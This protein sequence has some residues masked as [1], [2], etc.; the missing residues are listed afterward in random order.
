MQ[1][2]DNYTI[3]IY[4]PHW[5][6]KGYQA[7]LNNYYV[8]YWTSYSTVVELD[9][10]ICWQFMVWF[11]LLCLMPLST[12][13]QLYQGSQFYWRK[14]EYPVKTTNLCHK[15]LTK[16]YHIMLHRIL[17]MNGVRTHNFSG[18]STD[19]TG[20]FLK[21]CMLVYYH[22]QIRISWWLFD[23][24]IFLRINTPIL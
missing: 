9:L 21:V 10:Y 15:S 19:C 17:A 5:I 4:L 11:G 7:V 3:Y 24:A 18:D 23:W 20:S 13:F 12:I 2:S 6:L 14:P 22:M 16:L 1:A 8:N